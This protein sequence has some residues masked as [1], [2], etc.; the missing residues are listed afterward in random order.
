M[1]YLLLLLMCFVFS[2]ALQG[3]ELEHV[4]IEQRS[5]TSWN[6]KMKLDDVDLKGMVNA[7]I[8]QSIRHAASQIDT[9]IKQ[10]FRMI[11]DSLRY[12]ISKTKGFHVSFN[13]DTRGKV[14]QVWGYLFINESDKEFPLSDKDLHE[15]YHIFSNL[16][17]EYYKKTPINKNRFGEVG[18]HLSTF[19]RSLISA[20][21][22]P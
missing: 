21:G 8:R 22:E 18:Y 19:C 11:S 14:F 6:I 12:K 1:K 16:E 9:V 4:K 17:F 7:D 15:L 2:V 5:S 10:R 13:F 3:Q 20:E